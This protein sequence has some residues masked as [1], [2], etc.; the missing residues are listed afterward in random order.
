MATAD[1]AKCTSFCDISCSMMY[2]NIKS[3]S[4][5]RSTAVDGHW[6]K[7]DAFCWDTALS[8]LLVSYRNLVPILNDF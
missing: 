3:L 1:P 6:D 7:W 8:P 4:I 2:N 5:S